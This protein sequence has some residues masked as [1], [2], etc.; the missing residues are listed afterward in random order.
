MLFLGS[1]VPCF[2]WAACS[3][4]VLLWLCEQRGRCNGAQSLTSSFC[5][6]HV[7]S[8]KNSGSGAGG[9][10]PNVLLLIP[11]LATP[12]KNICACVNF[13]L[14]ASYTAKLPCPL[15]A[16]PPENIVY[17]ASFHFKRFSFYSVEWTEFRRS[18]VPKLNVKEYEEYGSGDFA[19][20]LREE[21]LMPP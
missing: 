1:Y 21:P 7:S 4:G 8:M 6:L 11:L 12:R 19:K 18:S 15:L 5:R 16:F 13:W 9:L 2:Q 20:V 17:L 10:V 3:Y 14:T